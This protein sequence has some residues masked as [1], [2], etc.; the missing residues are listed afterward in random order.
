MRTKQ[1][2]EILRNEDPSGECFIRWESVPV[3]ASLDTKGPFYYFDDDKKMHITNKGYRVNI[4]TKS[5]SDFIK[6]DLAN[7]YSGS[8]PIKDRAMLLEKLMSY[9][10]VETSEVTKKWFDDAMEKELDEWIKNYKK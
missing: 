9:F 3:S 8:D 7:W 2:I 10:D 4:K 1:L 5:S 6:D